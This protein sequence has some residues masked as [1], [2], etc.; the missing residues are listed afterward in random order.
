[1]LN[2]VVVS[3]TSVGGQIHVTPNSNLINAMYI[4]VYLYIYITH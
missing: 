4:Y 1:M 3:P 2:L